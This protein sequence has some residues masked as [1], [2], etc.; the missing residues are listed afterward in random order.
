[1]Y[2]KAHD[3]CEATTFENVYVVP[4]LVSGHFYAGALRAHIILQQALSRIIFDELK[5]ENAHAKGEEINFL[6]LGK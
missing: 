3:I 2:I 6:K 4:D 1:M 5:T